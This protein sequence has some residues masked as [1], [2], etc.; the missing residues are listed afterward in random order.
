MHPDGCPLGHPA[1]CPVGAPEN[2]PMSGPAN[3]AA[4][5]VAA[6]DSIRR[7]VPSVETDT[8][9]ASSVRMTFAPIDLSRSSVAGAGW[10]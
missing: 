3:A 10:P 2:G 9:P 6:A 7:S 8:V 4:V 1:A 5:H